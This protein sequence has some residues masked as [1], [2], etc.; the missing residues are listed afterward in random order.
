MTASS[1]QVPKVVGDNMGNV[2]ECLYASGAFCDDVLGGNT[3]ALCNENSLWPVVN[4]TEQKGILSPYLDPKVQQFKIQVRC[5]PATLFSPA[6]Y[7]PRSLQCGLKC[8]C[9]LIFPFD[10][11]FNTLVGIVMLAC[12]PE[13]K[14]PILKDSDHSACIC[15]TNSVFKFA[16]PQGIAYEVDSVCEPVVTSFLRFFCCC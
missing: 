7:K 13:R 2:M 10:E 8:V 14:H 5:N 4:K 15:M 9:E 6:V 16:K 12:T 11:D 1:V 3:A